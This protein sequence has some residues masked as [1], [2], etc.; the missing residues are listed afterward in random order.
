MFRSSLSELKNTKTLSIMSILVAINIVISSLFFPIGESLRIYIT[1]IV[2]TLA[3]I[4]SGP[5]AGL[6]WAFVVDIAGFLIHP[7]GPFFPGY[8]L[9]AMLSMFIYG[10][11]FYKQEITL[12]KI[13][14]AKFF[15]NF[16]CHVLLNSLWASILYSNV[17]YYYLVKSFIKNLILWPI[18]SIIIFL[19]LKLLLKRLNKLNYL[20]QD[21]IRLF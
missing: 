10:V 2:Y 4:I 16:I 15:V 9:T 12:L 21:Y 19:I 5:I 14:T 20:K 13:F 11:F 18:E 7:F 17:F 6:V 8:T 3:A 1:F